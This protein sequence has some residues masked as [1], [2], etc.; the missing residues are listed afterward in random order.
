MYCT[1]IECTTSSSFKSTRGILDTSSAYHELLLLLLM[2]N[3]IDY[4]IKYDCS[5]KRDSFAMF[6][7]NFILVICPKVLVIF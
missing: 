6:S 5:L 4:V 1:R 7:F 3:I 2:L